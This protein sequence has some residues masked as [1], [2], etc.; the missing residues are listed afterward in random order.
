MLV[1]KMTHYFREIYVGKHIKSISDKFSTFNRTAMLYK[2]L[3]SLVRLSGKFWIKAPS[4]LRQKCM[5]CSVYFCKAK[6]WFLLVW[7]RS[8]VA[9]ILNR[10]SSKIWNATDHLF[11]EVEWNNAEKQTC[12]DVIKYFSNYPSII[13]CAY[14]NSTLFLLYV[15]GT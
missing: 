10:I 15:Q 13:S 9:K 5:K 1:G 12:K 7:H 2:T 3:D 11:W 8:A 14:S 4:A 6:L